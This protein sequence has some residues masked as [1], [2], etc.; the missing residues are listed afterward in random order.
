MSAEHRF[1]YHF[2]TFFVPNVIKWNL[3]MLVPTKGINSDF[4]SNKR[5]WIWT[6]I[7]WIILYL[8][9][10]TIIN[11]WQ[12]LTMRQLKVDSLVFTCTPK[13]KPQKFNTTRM[14]FDPRITSYTKTLRNFYRILKMLFLMQTMF[15]L[16]YSLWLH[17]YFK[18]HSSHKKFKWKYLKHIHMLSI[19]L[20]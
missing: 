7:H 11:L 12:Q 1:K 13:Q 4:G 9:I 20:I 19:K 15:I 14:I 16:N 6:N 2:V 5:S 8:K 17:L 18:K 10:I 3:P